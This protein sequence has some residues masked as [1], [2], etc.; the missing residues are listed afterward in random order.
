MTSMPDQHRPHAGDGDGLVGHDRSQR[1][2]ALHDGGFGCHAE[3]DHLGTHR[4]SSGHRNRHSVHLA[5]RFGR[6]R[7]FLT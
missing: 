4:L 5:A 7:L 6:R 2:A 3:S 1:S